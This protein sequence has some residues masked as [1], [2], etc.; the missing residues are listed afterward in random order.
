MYIFICTYKSVR[1][2]W[3][4]R[5]WYQSTGESDSVRER[6]GDSVSVGRES[7]SES[8][9]ARKGRLVLA[10]LANGEERDG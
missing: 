3:V 6:E 10:T 7:E 1:E 9:R 8:E 5:R 2:W 4:V